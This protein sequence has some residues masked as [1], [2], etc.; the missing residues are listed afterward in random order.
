MQNFR[1]G[2]ESNLDRLVLKSFLSEC[3]FDTKNTYQSLL[4]ICS[5]VASMTD[6]N[7]LRVFKKL[8]LGSM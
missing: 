6:G 3:D 4:E 1:E 8:E 2:T 7:A 5:L